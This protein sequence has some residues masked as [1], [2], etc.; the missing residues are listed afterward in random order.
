VATDRRERVLLTRVAPNYPGAGRW[1]LPG[2]GTD[3]G[4]QPA[5]R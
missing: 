3:Y 1:H 2:G 5:P 4:E